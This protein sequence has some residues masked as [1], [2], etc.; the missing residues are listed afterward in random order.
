MLANGGVSNATTIF[1][2][3]LEQVYKGGTANNAIIAGGLEV[4]SG[5]THDTVVSGGTLNV[6]GVAASPTATPISAAASW[7]LSWAGASMA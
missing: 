1:G 3:G 6:L 5:T 7:A 2:L 4:V